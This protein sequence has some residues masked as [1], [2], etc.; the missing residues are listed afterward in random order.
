MKKI[1]AIILVCLIV[2]SGTSVLASMTCNYCGSGGREE[3][4]GDSIGEL[5]ALPHF[6]YL[7]IIQNIQKPDFSAFLYPNK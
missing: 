6:F 2:L 7:W 5:I 1:I 4:Q 3:C